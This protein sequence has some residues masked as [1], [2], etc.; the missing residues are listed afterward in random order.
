MPRP[1]NGSTAS[2]A[3]AKR[4]KTMVAEA[5]PSPRTWSTY[6]NMYGIVNPLPKAL[7]A[8]PSWTRRRVPSAPYF[9]CFMGDTPYSLARNISKLNSTYRKTALSKP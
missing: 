5:V 4:V 2:A 8:L 7:S 3:S 6:T 1:A 9:C